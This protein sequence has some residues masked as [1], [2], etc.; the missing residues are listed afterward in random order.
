TFFV[1]SS[2]TYFFPEF[3]FSRG[4]VL[5]SIG[6][7]IVFTSISRAIT[8]ILEQFSEQNKSKRIIIVGTGE[9]AKSLFDKISE[10]PNSNIIIDGFVA[11]S[12]DE[13][14]NPNLQIIGEKS[15][16][17]KIIKEKRPNEVIF[18]DEQISSSEM[19]NLMLEFSSQNV[20]FH[21]VK[22]FDELLAASVIQDIADI[23]PTVPS[24]NLSRFRNKAL[25]RIEDISVSLFLLTFGLPFI[26]ILRKEPFLFIK[27]LIRVLKGEISFIGL[28]K[29]SDDFT[30]AIGKIGIIGP[31]ASEQTHNLSIEAI[32]KL[33][34]YYLRHYT[35]SMDFDIIIKYLFGK[36][37]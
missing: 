1:L 35:L 24:Y 22:E 34:E 30:P 29:I 18:A 7:T 28:H 12:A 3:R 31:N 20:R 14:N 9:I 10:L 4:V 33:N 16:L 27:M 32:K 26:F 15:Y 13:L 25:K 23:E 2:L 8:K 37:K 36:N 17:N 5:M 11:S 6:F 21:Q 19:I